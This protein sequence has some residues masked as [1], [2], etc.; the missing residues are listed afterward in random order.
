MKRVFNQKKS[1]RA[2]SAY[3]SFLIA[4]VYLYALPPAG[5]IRH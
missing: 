3:Q 1:L 4:R 5:I 2:A